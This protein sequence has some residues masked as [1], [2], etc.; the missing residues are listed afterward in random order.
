VSDATTQWAIKQIQDHGLETVAFT[1]LV[2]I[3]AAFGI[4]YLIGWAL[5]IRKARIEIDR[6]KAEARKASGENFDRLAALRDKSN[7]ER[8]NVK[9]AM[10]TLRDAL[11]SN[12][13]PEH[14]ITCRDEMCNLYDADYLPAV[15]HYTEMIAILVDR[16]ESLH[17]A[18]TELIP[19]LKTMCSFVQMMNMEKMLERT[20]GKPILLR[21]E[22]RDG[23]LDRVDALIPWWHFK[24]RWELRKIRKKT[25]S[26]L[27]KE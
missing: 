7:D 6:A 13:P 27:R 18:K 11:N 26:Y 21:R 24:L 15:T 1:L 8:E 10:G 19:G 5:T 20:K 4:G 3:L 9:L 12:K 17:R 23:F 16:K 2:V 22:V 14:L 25:D